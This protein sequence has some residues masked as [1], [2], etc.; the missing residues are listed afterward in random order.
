MTTYLTLDDLVGFIADLG[1][2][3]MRDLGLLEGA[4]HRPSAHYFGM[5]L[6]EG[7]DMKAAVLRS[8]SFAIIRSSMATSGWGGWQ[9]SSSMA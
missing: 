5:E 2:G 8:R 6:Y 3:P 1:V 7:L 4:A 9:S